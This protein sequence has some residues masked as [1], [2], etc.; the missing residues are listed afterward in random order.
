MATW[1]FG[2]REDGCLSCTW[3]DFQKCWSLKGKS[4]FVELF[5]SNR[6]PGG[7][8]IAGS[9]SSHESSTR[10][11]GRVQGLKKI[12]FLQAFFQAIHSRIIESR[13]DFA[14]AED[15]RADLKAMEEEKE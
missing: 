14:A 15:I 2:R 6:S 5:D 11:N 4:I 7:G 13:T 9:C 10:E 1:H 12:I 8:S 3:M